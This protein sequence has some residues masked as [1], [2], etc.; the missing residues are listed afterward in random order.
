MTMRYLPR[1]MDTDLMQWSGSQDRKPL[2]LRG[3]RQTGKT[4][5]I[6]ALG[7][8]YEL[9]AELN[10]E[11][12]DDRRLVGACDSADDLLTAIAVHRDV[13]EFPDRT[14][15]FIDEVQEDPRVVRW[16]RFLHE[17]RP[18]LH[19]VAA[20]SLMEVRL[21]ER[22]FSFPV[23]RVTFRY[24]HPMSFHE[25]LFA[26]GRERLAKV[27]EHAAAV[28]DPPSTA[29]HLLAEAAF[30][31]YLIVGGMPEAVARWT[32]GRSAVAVRQVHGDLIQAFAEDLHRYSG[33][34]DFSHLE[35]A[36]DALR[37]HYGKRFKYQ[38][39]APGF[40]SRQ[41]QTALGRL[42]GAM[43][44]RRVWPT[45]DLQP[46]LQVKPRSAPK[47]LPLDVGLAASSAGIPYRALE[48]ADVGSVLDGRIAESVVGQLLL[49]RQRRTRQDLFFWVRE[50][51]RAN[52]EVDHLVGTHSGVLPTEVKAGAAGSLRSLHQLLWRSGGRVG[53]R[54]HGGTW[55]DERHE[56]TMP[57]G[58]LEYRLLS[59]PLYMAEYAPDL[60]LEP[61]NQNGGV[62]Q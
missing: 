53:L 30:R 4:E 25:F 35:A 62:L 44:C 1:S 58:V 12:H 47:L 31:E 39:F 19:V 27:L 52:A 14:L 60:A 24:L 21:Q 22:G 6:R 29:I 13:T 40:R 55:A 61:G 10:L 23:G 41:M 11:R 59:W 7:R 57:D 37:H 45:A 5:T 28:L 16:L 46:P 36:F 18:E 3:A 42:E 8:N 33:V 50:T 15:L 43:I 9:F 20:G 34:R 32:D 38:Q 26:T 49:S 48:T 17:D 54:L 2:V 56:V 51:P